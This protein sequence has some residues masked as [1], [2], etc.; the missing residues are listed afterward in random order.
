M[1]GAL[2]LCTPWIVPAF[3]L[4]HGNSWVL[5]F[6]SF[7]CV[8]YQCHTEI[9]LGTAASLIVLGSLMIGTLM[10]GP[11]GMLYASVWTLVAAALSRVQWILVRRGGRIADEQMA[12]AERART[13]QRVADAVRADERAL[14]NALHDTAATTLL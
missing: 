11:N 4:A 7:A 10:A 13:A 8:G 9:V 1:L 3:W 2:G 5:A 14:A 12:E 6:V